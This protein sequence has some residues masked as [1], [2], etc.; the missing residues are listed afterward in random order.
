MALLI[1]VASGNA[2]DAAPLEDHLDTLMQGLLGPFEPGMEGA[3]EVTDA[4]IED[5]NVSLLFIQPPSGGSGEPTVTEYT[6]GTLT[7]TTP[8]MAEGGLF[9]EL[10]ASSTGGSLSG[11]FSACWCDTLVAEVEFMESNSGG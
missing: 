6:T 7:L 11:T 5:P 10:D 8:A 4:V 1:G 2:C 3:F 9:G